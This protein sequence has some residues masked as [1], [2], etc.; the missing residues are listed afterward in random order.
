MPV[1]ILIGSLVVTALYT[2]LE[3][4]ERALAPA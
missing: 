2:G 4:D 1:A 3:L